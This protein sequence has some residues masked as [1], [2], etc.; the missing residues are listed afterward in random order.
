MTGSNGELRAPCVERS[1]IHMALL[2]WRSHFFCHFFWEGGPM[3]TVRLRLHATKGGEPPWLYM[4][5]WIRKP[6]RSKLCWNVCQE[7]SLKKPDDNKLEGR[8]GTGS[9]RV[10]A[11]VGGFN[12]WGWGWM[13]RKK[14]G[15]R[16]RRKKTHQNKELQPTTK[17][18]SS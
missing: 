18:I 5:C 13:V 9:H 10:L 7:N 15:R 6:I 3:L 16:R 17:I 11:R 1:D 2:W 12:C 8:I 4:Q 14:E